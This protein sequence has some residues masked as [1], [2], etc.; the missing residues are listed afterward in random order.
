[1]SAASM[2]VDLNVVLDVLFDRKPHAEAA[3]KLWAAIEEGHVNAFIAGHSITTL[4]YLAQ[5]SLGTPRAKSLVEDVLSVFKIASISDETLR[6]AL[7]L[8]GND[9]E[10]AVTAVAG[11]MADCEVVVTRDKSGFK[12]AALVVMSPSEAL[13]WIAAAP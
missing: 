11:L 5:K 7:L 2:I 1:M 10:D 3:S 8:P 6:R 9:F 12:G 13:A 4:Y